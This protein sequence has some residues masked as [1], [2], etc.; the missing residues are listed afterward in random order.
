MTENTLNQKLSEGAKR[1]AET[2]L[3]LKQKNEQRI[4][5]LEVAK[6]IK[7]QEEEEKKEKFEKSMNDTMSK[8]S[9]SLDMQRLTQRQKFEA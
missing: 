9:L 7:Q 8:M 4:M 6:T 3:R 5:R 1:K 2:L